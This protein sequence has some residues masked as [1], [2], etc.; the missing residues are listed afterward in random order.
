M[1]KSKIQIFCVFHKVMSA[2]LSL[3][4]FS[5][6]EINQWFTFYAVNQEVSSKKFIDLDGS[7]IHSFSEMPKFI[8]EFSLSVHNPLLQER[9][10]METSCYIHLL[11]NN[12]YKQHEWVGICQYDMSWCQKSKVILSK[13]SHPSALDQWLGRIRKPVVYAQ[14]AAKR[15][16]K[17]GILHPMASSS[18]FNW[19]YLLESYNRFFSTSFVMQDFSNSPLTLW[20]TYLMPQQIFV[21]L[22]SWLKCLA[23]EVYPWANQLPYETHWGVLGGL[24]ERAEAMFMAIHSA[25]R[26]IQIKKLYLSHDENISKQLNIPKNHYK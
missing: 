19:D 26:R 3:S 9:G 16:S 2:P 5:K 15:C 1:S 14:I 25:Q 24:T 17:N 4:V 10:F 7:E 21:E 12:L 8:E 18:T 11:D 23:D 13:L 20:Q 22:A 6:E